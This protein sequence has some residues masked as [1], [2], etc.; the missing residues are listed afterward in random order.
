MSLSAAV[1]TR[2]KRRKKCGQ[3]SS[4]WILMGR[5]S[6]ITLTVYATPWDSSGRTIAYGPPTWVPIISATT[7][8]QIRFIQLKKKRI[9]A[10]HIVFRPAPKIFSDPQ[11]N[12]R[13]KKFDCRKVPAAHTPFPS[14]S[15]PL[16]LEY[17][18]STN[19]PALAGSFLVA[20]HGSTKRSLRRRGYSV[21]K[22]EESTSGAIEDF[23]TG[24]FDGTRVNGRPADI[25]SYGKNAFLLTDDHSGVVYYIY[26]R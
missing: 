21:V 19:D 3:Q 13:N 8:R 20:L 16:G 2:V 4:R 15:S 11:F 24:F 7:V 10:G 23:I 1:V 25:F 18:D 17:F 5:T 14:H 12:L 26:R 6:D 9:M 22:I